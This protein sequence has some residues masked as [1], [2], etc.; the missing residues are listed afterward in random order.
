LFL[1]DLGVVWSL[2]LFY[3]YCTDAGTTP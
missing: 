2:L 3:Y 1:F